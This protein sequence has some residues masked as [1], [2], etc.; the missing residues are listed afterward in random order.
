MENKFSEIG[1]SDDILKAITELGFENPTDVQRESIPKILQKKDLIVMSK[2]GSGKTAAFGIPILQQMDKTSDEPNALM[3]APTRELAVQVEKDIRVLAKYTD[4]RTTS[5]YGQH[6][7]DTEIKAMKKGVDVV[8]GT[9][10]RVYDHI[11]RKNLKTSNIKFLVLD[12]ADRMLDMGFYDQVVQIIKALPRQR[13]TL[14]F[15]ATMPPEIKRICQSY[16]N[17]PVTIELESESKTVDTVKQFYYKVQQHEKRKQLV[18]FLKFHQPESCMVFCNT[19]DEVDRVQQFLQNNGF[20]ADALH[21]ANNQNKRM[22]TIEDFKKGKIQVLVATDVAA[23]GIHIDDL[24]LVVNYDVPDDKNSYVH[25]VGRT[26]RAG[27]EGLAISIVTSD[28]IMTLYEIEEHV[29][30]LIEE[31]P[32]PTDEAVA[33]ALAAA[34]GKWVGVEAP[35]KVQRNKGKD[36]HQKQH[37]GNRGRNTQHGDSRDRNK[38]NG[39]NHRSA[40]PKTATTS[41]GT[42]TATK[43]TDKKYVNKVHETKKPLVK[44]TAK[45]S[46]KPTAKPAHEH[47]S[48][49]KTSPKPTPKPVAR[50]AHKKSSKPTPSKPKVRTEKKMTKGLGEIEFVV[51]DTPKKAGILGKVKKIF[52]G[53]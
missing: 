47:K 39:S 40:K 36:H 1:V 10:G 38:S 35:P 24:S 28:S 43:S 27:N 48:S 22:R 5:V 41:Q 11:K 42:S 32:L 34:D 25:R 44:Q 20:W 12:E 21:G 8:C 50:P 46:V 37:N 2:T 3:L 9:P 53:Q 31:E 49:L 15:S 30:I 17:D 26:G 19:R 4:V 16:M 23:R 14:L 13:V 6:N 51:K 29:N 18:R 45:P 52:G 7:M 33:Q